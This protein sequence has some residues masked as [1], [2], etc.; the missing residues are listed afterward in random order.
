MKR[1][2]RTVKVDTCDLWPLL[3]GYVRYSMGRRS[4]APSTARELV[5]A[6]SPSLPAEQRR[7][8]AEEIRQE[9]A[10]EERGG[11]TLGD[12]CD[13]QTWRE[14]LGWMDEREARDALDRNP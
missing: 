6:Y 2:P 14:L 12:K 11:R 3:L 1:A 13:D 5:R 7:Q 4:T 8:I 10:I 9:L